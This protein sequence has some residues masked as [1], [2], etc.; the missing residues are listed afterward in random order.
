[1]CQADGTAGAKGWL[2]WLGDR[3]RPIGMLVVGPRHPQP[4]W[5]VGGRRVVDAVSLT[6]QLGGWSEAQLLTWPAPTPY[7]TLGASL[8]L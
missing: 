4:D 5:P 1:M 8:L 3:A 6:G 2:G 7:P